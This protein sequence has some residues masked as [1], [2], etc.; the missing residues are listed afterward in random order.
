MELYS[1]RQGDGW[2][3]AL[4]PGTKRQKTLAEVRE[5]AIDE[6]ALKERFRTL[7]GG[8]RD[9]DALSG[10]RRGCSLELPP[11]ATV[12]DLEGLAQGLRLELVRP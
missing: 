7:G 6:S 1:W 10:R 4:L 5:A 12:Q 3:Y 11:Q 9:L 2:S 8:V